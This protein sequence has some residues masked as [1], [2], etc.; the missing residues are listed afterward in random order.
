MDWNWGELATGVL[1]VLLGW[2]TRHY[3]GRKGP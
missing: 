1:G 2:L 3:S